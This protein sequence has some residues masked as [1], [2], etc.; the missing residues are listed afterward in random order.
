[1]VRSPPPGVVKGSYH[2]QKASLPL[3]SQIRHDLS[4][5]K[6]HTVRVQRAYEEK[7]TCTSSRVWESL[8]IIA[9]CRWFEK[10]SGSEVVLL[11][12]AHVHVHSPRVS[13]TGDNF[14]SMSSVLNM[15]LFS[16]IPNSRSCDE[17]SVRLQIVLFTLGDLE[18]NAVSDTTTDVLHV[19]S[20]SWRQV[21]GRSS[22]PDGFRKVV[23]PQRHFGSRFHSRLLTIRSWPVCTA[24]D[25]VA[26]Q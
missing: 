8:R 21:L 10:D 24:T 11:F 9:R 4:L 26:R 3:L 19:P 17:F 15:W 1:M 12:V 20:I 23:P 2:G 13:Y 16:K 7:V 25:T 14:A 18:L 6:L 22:W 5:V